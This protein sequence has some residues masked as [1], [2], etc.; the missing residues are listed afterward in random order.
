MRVVF[1]VQSQ[2]F[3]KLG[4][5]RLANVAVITCLETG[6]MSSSKFFGVISSEISGVVMLRQPDDQVF[7]C[8]FNDFLRHGASFIDLENTFDLR[9]QPLHQPE[10]SPGDPKEPSLSRLCGI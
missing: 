9:Q 5:K 10:I 1:Q 4:G 2:A 6:K 7:A 8:C 3:L